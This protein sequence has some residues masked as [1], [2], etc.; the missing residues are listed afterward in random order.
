MF[1]YTLRRILWLFP[2]LLVVGLITFIVMRAAPGG[3]FDRDPNRRGLSRTAQQALE[4]KFGLDKPIWRQFLRYML[5]DRDLDP[6]TGQMKWVCGAICGNLG[7]TYASRGSKTVEDTLFKQESRNTPSRFYFSARLGVQALILAI[8]IGIPLGVIAAL[9]QNTIVDYVSLFISTLFTVLPSFIVGLLL[10]IFA[11]RVLNGQRWFVDLFGRFEV[12]PRRW[13][14][15]VKP[16]ILPTL[17]LGFGSMAFMTRLTRSS[18]L[19]VVRQDYVRTARA[20][21]L[22][23]WT[24]I[25]RHVLKNSLIP[26]VTILGPALAGL[27]TGSFFTET[28]FNVPGMG[29]AFVQAVGQRDYS[30]IMGTGLFYAFLIAAANLTVDLIYGLLDPRIKVS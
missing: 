27:L 17:A 20:K 18:V 3:P 23:G 15:N 24:V 6:K 11:V 28:I 7:P 19:E 14:G 4:R 10:L 9:K 22:T 26:V 2:V 25:T 13:T 30:M 1:A 29:R 5:V 12:N 16:W 8:V 21:G